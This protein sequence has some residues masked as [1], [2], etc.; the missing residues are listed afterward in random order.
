[1]LKACVKLVNILITGVY[2]VMKISSLQFKLKRGCIFGIIV[3]KFRY[4]KE[5]KLVTAG[6]FS[7]PSAVGYWQR[8][9]MYE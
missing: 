5:K 3:S 7:E 1:L 2:L 9:H 6:F 4:L 8:E